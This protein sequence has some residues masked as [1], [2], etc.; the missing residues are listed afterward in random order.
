MKL[1]KKPIIHCL[2]FNFL[3]SINTVNFNYWEKVET[4]IGVQFI[5]VL[6]VSLFRVTYEILVKVCVYPPCPASLLKARFCWKMFADI[7]DGVCQCEF[8]TRGGRVGA[9]VLRWRGMGRSRRRKVWCFSNAM[10][11]DVRVLTGWGGMMEM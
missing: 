7:L 3:K 9:T 4:L 11:A 6:P 5:P 8:G 2:Y 1:F 10:E